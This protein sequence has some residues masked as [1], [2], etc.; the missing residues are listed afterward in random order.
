MAPQ[1]YSG[2]VFI[3]AEELRRL[4][5]D[6][7]QLQYQKEDTE[8]DGFG[9]RAQ[10]VIKIR[11]EHIL[12][13][14]FRALKD[15]L[16]EN[17]DIIHFWNR[18][19]IYSGEPYTCFMG[20]DL[21]LIKT[22]GKR[23]LYRFTGNDVRFSSQDMEVNP[24]SFFHYGYKNKFDE[25]RQRL[26]VEYLKE[27]VDKFLVQDPEL[28]QFI[29]EAEIVPRC[30]ILDEW[31]NIGITKNDKPLVVHTSTNDLIKGTNFIQK[32]V[33]ELQSEGLQFEFKIIR[34]LPHIEAIE[35]YKK[36]DIC[37]DNLH[38]GCLCVFALEAMALGKPTM[39]YINE[40]VYK[41]YPEIP[42]E[43]VN[44]DNIKEKLRELIKDYD[45]RQE[46]SIKGR[47]FVEEHHD[48]R[49]VSKQ[50]LGIYTD[51]MKKDLIC[52]SGYKDLDYFESHLQDVIK[53]KQRANY[54]ERQSNSLRQQ[55]ES[56]QS[57]PMHKLIKYL[58]NIVNKNKM[59]EQ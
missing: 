32:A 58:K 57:N 50:L 4:N 30:L 3:L 15:I 28:L 6:I 12:E 31:P 29:P 36:S 11:N 34:G 35:W 43:N 7:V 18:T 39:I 38:Q 14:Q 24:Y 10:R 17:Y 52:P 5:T 21:P 48:S 25:S 41:P 59:K 20:L 55:L 27:Y 40:N 22:R 44:P 49:K 37:I 46:L 45:R 8:N 16:S 23:I 53:I 2:Q 42:I 9:Y 54:L 19:F 1:N 13:D 51:E 33:D 47:I 26:Y 56:I